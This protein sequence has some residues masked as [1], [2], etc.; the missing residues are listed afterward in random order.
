[1]TGPAW[2]RVEELYH[3]A[4]EKL[5]AER[6]AFLGEAC[7]GDE[8][9]RR[10]V[11][12]LLNHEREAERLM[13][14]PAATAA[15]QKLAVT[16]G[17]RLGPYEVAELLG[18]GGMGEVYRAR[19]TRLGREVAIKVLPELVA[20]D[21][22]ALRRFDREAR[23]VAALS[24]PRICALHDVGRENGVDFAVMELLEGETLRARL[25]RSPLPV[26]KA[27]EL[28]QQIC[29]GLAAAHAKG[30][31]HRDLKPEN[32]FLTREGMKIL[33]FGLARRTAGLEGGD[34]TTPRTRSGLVLGTVGYL[35]PEQAR[36][37][38]ADARSDVFA[39]G[40]V[41]YEMLSGRR[42]FKRQ[43]QAETLTAILKEDPPE[44][45][46][47]GGP[48][49]PALG[50]IV[51][52]CLE[53]DPE[54]RFQNARDVAFALDA[55]SV[56]SEG[57]ALEGEGLRGRSSARRWVLPAIAGGALAALLVGAVAD[58]L[59]LRGP[60]SAGPARVVRSQIDLPP[61]RPIEGPGRG[62]HPTRRDLAL[63]PDG[64]LLVWTARTSVDPYD[65]ALYRRRLDTGEVTPLSGGESGAQPFF[66][67]DGRW[68]GF[69]SRV[70]DGSWRRL[71]KVR[72]EGGIPVDLA[73]V[74]DA[75]PMGATWGADDRIYLGSI[76]GGVLSV[77]AEGGAAR[78]VTTIDS[79]HEVGHRLP[80]VL[81]G[82]RELL[83]TVA[84]LHYGLK[85][86]IEAFSLA[87]GKR[88]VVVE[89]GADGHY[90]A[91]GH[92]VF[93]RRGV[94]MAAP[95]DLS[96]LELTA[97]P[98]TVV[99]GISQALNAG[100]SVW[101]SGAAQFTASDSG[102]LA[103][104]AGGI[105]PDSPVELLL[106]DETGRTEPLPGF[107]RPLVSPQLSFSPDGRL[108]A[109]NEQERS[110][111]LWLFDLERQ[112]FRALSDRGIAGSP[113]WSPDGKR[114]AAI[115]AE[116]GPMQLWIVPTDRSEWVQ[117][118][119]GEEYVE[120]PSWSPDGRFLAFTAS[121]QSADILIYRFE[122]RKVVPFLATKSREAYPEFSPDG[123][124]LAYSSDEGGREEVY[125]T[126]FPGR[127]KTLTVS[128]RGGSD[129]KWSRDGKR[130]F[131]FSLPSSD[132]RWSMMTVAA[133]QGPELALGVPTV[134]FRLPEGVIDLSTHSYELH[135]DG[136]HF[137][138]GRFKKTEPLSPITRLELVQNWF[139]ELDRLAPT[140]Q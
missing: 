76:A 111:L 59:W 91:S 82:G 116:A 70:G 125:V 62:H 96:R 114:L 5:P 26:A 80:S 72:V 44:L 49:P 79:A 112:T 99:E 15:T 20:H 139:A 36:G 131:Y 102:S 69:V 11:Q 58:R 35:S 97:P 108:L 33:D 19:D 14:R 90:L 92:L 109:F 121:R 46:A 119:K 86:R 65:S 8:A 61:E 132:G 1:M 24:H 100:G 126:S 135:P 117:L 136:R 10:E 54:D 29:Q 64:T 18:A 83:V 53:K 12:S 3:A 127:E 81:P 106:V 30:I 88:K 68:V 107:D 57:S 17:T 21:P 113:R 41:L 120:D 71:R 40:A 93:L 13:E 101:N 124:W 4:L 123:G 50:R 43:T 7:H 138:F 31:V 75:L 47:P 52:R 6:E 78:E 28:A 34:A 103:Y 128:R 27:V 48:V 66:S 89:D 38:V 23:A 137:V 130:L 95:F 133:G 55:I 140:R 16:R 105:F 45:V 94:L 104:A 39:L 134:L 2:T 56:T 129:P 98:V 122:D 60:E 115:W 67:P 51:R 110:G 42:A 74:P 37:E 77:A 85:M 22:E 63:S 118:T 84:P 25:A 9:L 73:D 87:T 32:L